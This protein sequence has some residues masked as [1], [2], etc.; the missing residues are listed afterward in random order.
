MTEVDEEVGSR[1]FQALAA[2]ERGD[3]GRAQREFEM[4]SLELPRFAPAWDGL[5]RCYELQGE[6]KAAGECFRRAIRLD[7]RGWASRFH[8]GLALHRAG[9]L[10][11]A[12][13]WLREAARAA[14]AE[15]RIHYRLGQCYF[16]LGDYAA[17][18]RCY[19]RALEQPERDLLDA[20]LYVAI[21]VVE[22]ERGDFAA[23]DT[24]YQRACLLSPDDPEVY[25]RWAVVT[26]RQG[27]VLAAE[28]LA[29]RACA[30]DS[31]SLRGPVLQV[32]LALDSGRW[33]SAGRHIDALAARD[34]GSRLAQALRAEL[35]LRRGDPIA[36]RAGALAALRSEG[37]ASD[38]ALD[39]AL[40][41]LRRLRG[42][43]ERCRGYRLVVE[44]GE[45]SRSYYRPFVVLAPDEGA[46]RECVSDLQTE[47][48][49]CPW[50]IVEVESFPH[51]GE[52]E[53]GV[54]HVLL[55]RVLFD[56]AAE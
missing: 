14:P 38:Q 48:D 41:V 40:A 42:D 39:R 11:E 30:L 1:Y 35:D 18:R 34:D 44:A 21:G 27:D 50:S 49:S 20:E 4:L 53:P 43:R 8:W 3:T 24:A 12:C 13:R 46:A 28:R 29:A 55:T 26:A 33:E 19:D 22:T 6:L 25:Y 51:D 15:R 7:R 17:A 2:L 52:T 16:D 37:P 5:G 9:E 56:R 36:A 32:E 10:K 47:L 31:R 54:Y 23:A 45:G